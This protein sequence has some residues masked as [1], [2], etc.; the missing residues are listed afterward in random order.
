MERLSKY[1]IPNPPKESNNSSIPPSKEPIKSEIAGKSHR[2]NLNGLKTEFNKVKKGI[3]RRR[4]N[5]FKFHENPEIPPD[6]NRSE[7]GIMNLKIKQKISEVLRSEAGAD[8]FHA[9]QSLADM[10]NK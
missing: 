8:A 4:D 10:I 1:E 2:Q 6:N 7:R 5:I 9:I 3:L